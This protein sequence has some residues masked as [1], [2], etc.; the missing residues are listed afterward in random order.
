MGP[1]AVLVVAIAMLL[2]A[3]NLSEPEAK[4]AT[5]DLSGDAVQVGE[6]VTGEP[7][8]IGTICSCSGPV[9][10]STAQVPAVWK[11]WVRWTN[12]HGGINGHP[13]KVIELDDGL[14]AARSVKMAKDLIDE[15]NV[16]AIVGEMDNLNGL[17]ADYARE[18][19]VPVIG[20]AVFSSV[21]ETNPYFFATGAQT[22]TQAYGTLAEVEKMGA[23]KVSIMVCA[24]SPTCADNAATLEKLSDLFDGVDVVSN[25]RIAANAP[26]YTAACL[27]ARDADADVIVPLVPPS[28]VPRLVASCKQQGFAP[29]L[30]TSSFVPGNDWAADPNLDGFVTVAPNQSLWDVSSEPNKTLNE[31]LNTFAKGIYEKP[32]LNASNSSV[33]S[34]G[35]V[36]KLAA[37]RGDIGPSSTSQDVLKGLYTFKA[38]TLGGLTPPLTYTQGDDVPSLVPCWFVSSIKDGA[39]EAPN[40]AEASCIPD[41]HRDAVKDS[42]MK[43]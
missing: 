13:V 25:Q 3:C 24:E 7:V 14:D 11:A 28:V 33:W 19:G 6:E 31:A 32:E 34:A 17:W 40:G 36:F 42:F 27:A 15:H 9:S 26:N 1:V 22:P 38:E 30:V 21:Y 12:T 39:W 10:S 35:E 43:P 20:A 16:M 4:G 41:K 8:V 18:R 5:N 2:S 37:E 29:K 23:S